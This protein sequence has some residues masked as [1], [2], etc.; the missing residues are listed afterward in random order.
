MDTN[1]D[2]IRGENEE[3]GTAHF[4]LHN[5][6]RVAWRSSQF[7]CVAKLFARQN[8]ARSSDFLPIEALQRTNYHRQDAETKTHT[9]GKTPM[10]DVNSF[11]SSTMSLQACVRMSRAD[12]THNVIHKARRFWQENM[13]NLRRI[14]LPENRSLNSSLIQKTLVD[15]DIEPI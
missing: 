10:C 8:I 11:F 7:D 15:C 6:H 1:P 12:P 3:T 13:S 2:H 4:Q 14:A 9:L 5:L